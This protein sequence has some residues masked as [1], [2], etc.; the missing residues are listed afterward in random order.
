MDPLNIDSEVLTTSDEIEQLVLKLKSGNALRKR[1]P[2][3][4]RIHIDRLQP[5]LC[6][7]RRPDTRPDHGTD[8]LL[9]GQASYIL[10]SG[11]EEYQPLLKE[12]ITRLLDVIVEA[13]GA[14]LLLELWSAPDESP[15]T[16]Q[17]APAPA[18]F[19]IV[20]ARYGVPDAT[21]ES[22]EHALIAT[23]RDR[24]PEITINYSSGATSPGLPPLLS[25]EEEQEQNAYLVGL[26][27]PPVYRDSETGK[28]IPTELR[29]FTGRLGRALRQA[30]FT[31][32][33]ARARYRP[34][35]YEELG[36]RAMTRAVSVADDGLAQ[37][38]DSFDLLL[39]ATPVNTD[40][41][42]QRFVEANCQVI[43]E[44][45][46]RPQT[47]DPGALKL[48]LYKVPIERI[49]DPALHYLFAA[50]RD[51]LDRMITMIADRGT[52]NFLLES[53]QVFG[54]PDEPLVAIA[55][56]LLETLQPVANSDGAQVACAKRF[57]EL[58]EHE[59]AH[60]RKHWPGLPARVEIRSDVPGLMV[61]RGHFLVGDSARVSE[62]R[63][64][65][66]LHHEIGTHILTY[67]NGL[68]QP[69][70]QFHTGMPGY[71]QTQEG[72][73]M[74]SEYLSGGL[75]RQRMRLLAGRVVA[76]DSLVQ[77][78]DFLE[79]FRLL[80]DVHGFGRRA[81]FIIAMRVHRG[82][83]L[84][85]DA[86]YLRGLIGVLDHLAKGRSFDDLMLGKVA[87]EH[88][89]V[90]SELRWRRVVSPG[91]LKPRYLED[92]EALKRLAALRKGVDLMMLVD[93]GAP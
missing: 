17:G 7:Y 48:A 24:V 23:T 19:G 56:R 16:P 1:L 88:I 42:Y 32:I 74:L 91:P 38:G 3:G 68:H 45:L 57:A 34:A 79:T 35:H 85:K 81:A 75:T 80:N 5:F 73:A 93:R 26:E 20:A 6:V 59:L 28:I 33:R 40:A 14:V 78:A 18:R 69:L 62:T 63:I 27:I 71:E 89:E 86:V 49:E 41:A 65:A 31:F 50:Q 72:L 54:R 92:P 39:H 44:F 8:R 22:L 37:V 61:S 52:P 36:R 53:Q 2:G 4:G 77:G 82:G 84:T 55:R 30:F 83:G 67:Y 51:E 70:S 46:Y 9:L 13:F 11:S 43:P 58:A 21:I 25:P 10:S 12:L 64:D 66:T 87:L 60:Y 47:I 76:V 15:V 90:V 29:H